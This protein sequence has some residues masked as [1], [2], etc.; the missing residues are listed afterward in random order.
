[1]SFYGQNPTK[2]TLII[3]LDMLKY[4]TLL[5]LHKHIYISLIVKVLKQL[6]KRFHSEKLI[7]LKDRYQH[8]S[9]NHPCCH[10]STN[11]GTL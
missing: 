6:F 10:I 7:Q 4:S 1:M 8:L 9:F 2:Q 11:T 3:F 5:I